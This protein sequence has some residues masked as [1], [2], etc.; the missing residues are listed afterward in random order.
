MGGHQH[1]HH[2]VTQDGEIWARIRRSRRE[3]RQVASGMPGGTSAV[4][5]PQVTGGFRL[6]DVRHVVA[7][8]EAASERLGF[9]AQ[10]LPEVGL[11]RLARDPLRA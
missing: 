2:R 5:E 3:A 1:G 10:V 4:P 9:T 8:P 11:P 6:G 7:S